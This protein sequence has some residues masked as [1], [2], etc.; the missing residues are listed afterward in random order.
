LSKTWPQM[1]AGVVV[2]TI[3]MLKAPQDFTFALMGA[4]GLV[5]ATPFAVITASPALGRLFARI[6]I[7]HLP[8]EKVVPEALEPLCLAA[9]EIGLPP[10]FAT[11]PR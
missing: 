8:E 2:L 11:G 3:V 1:L 9:L 6:G 10:P 5:L 4:A 7:C